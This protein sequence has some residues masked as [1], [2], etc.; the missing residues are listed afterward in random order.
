[1]VSGGMAYNQQSPYGAVHGN[2]HRPQQRTYEAQ[3]QYATKQNNYGTGYQGFDF[4]DGPVYESN[5]P[6]VHDRYGPHAGNSMQYR[7]NMQQGRGGP[8]D[9]RGYD[10][11]PGSS[12]NNSQNV[13]KF[14]TGN[15]RRTPPQ[16]RPFGSE[17]RPNAGHRSH[18]SS[19]QYYPSSA[20]GFELSQPSKFDEQDQRGRQ[21]ELQ[22]PQMLQNDLP[23]EPNFD[24]EKVHEIGGGHGKSSQAQY[25]K[26]LPQPYTDRKG[27]NP[28]NQDERNIADRQQQRYKVPYGQEDFH[29]SSGPH[30]RLEQVNTTYPQISHGQPSKNFHGSQAARFQK[31]R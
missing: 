25:H 6:F 21:H 31:P 27:F 14:Y 20:T 19:Q 5:E 24:E 13:E 7:A 15:M 28:A 9:G 10:R 22:N 11:G 1:M 23:V 26:P 4:G 16:K 18:G 8:G 30:V 29:G 3:Q 2:S 17:W 12:D